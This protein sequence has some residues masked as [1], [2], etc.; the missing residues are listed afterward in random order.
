MIDHISIGVHDIDRSRRFYDAALEPLGYARLSHDSSS[1]GYGRDGVALWILAAKHPVP[2]DEHS[3][4][5]ICLTAPTQ[6]AVD[7]FHAAALE[8]GGNDNGRPGLAP[9]MARDIMPLS[10]SIPTVTGSR[11]IAIGAEPD[12]VGSTLQR[13]NQEQDGRE[14]RGHLEAAPR[15]PADIVDMSAAVGTAPIGDARDQ[16]DRQRGT[17]GGPHPFLHRHRH[18]AMARASPI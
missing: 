2:P 5:H 10:S 12:R 1:L 15:H 13:Q 18:S 17:I 14:E 9:I 3:G 7:L 4:L 11:L 16:R 8:K 6:K